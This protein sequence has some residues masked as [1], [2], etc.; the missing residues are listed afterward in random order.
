MVFLIQGYVKTALFG[1][2]LRPTQFPVQCVGSN[3][4][5]GVPGRLF[6]QAFPNL[7]FIFIY[8]TIFDLKGSTP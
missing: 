1:V 8:H 2:Q 4:H 5:C 7:P 6:T 3:N